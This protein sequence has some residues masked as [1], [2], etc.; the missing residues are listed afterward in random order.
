[1]HFDNYDADLSIMKPTMFFQNLI[2][3]GMYVDM[4]GEIIAINHQTGE[5]L[6]V[7]FIKRKSKNLISRISGKVHGL[8]KS[9]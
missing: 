8:P 5:K 4:E 7:D 2:F 3:G 1:M 6:V 9:K